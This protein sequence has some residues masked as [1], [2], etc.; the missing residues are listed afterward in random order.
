LSLFLKR[1]LLFEY[2]LF[3]N[4]VILYFKNTR[5]MTRSQNNFFLIISAASLIHQM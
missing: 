1:L 3:N 5:S 4:R 2:A